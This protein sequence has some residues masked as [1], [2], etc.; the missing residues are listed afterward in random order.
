MV[1]GKEPKCELLGPFALVIQ[2]LMGL[3]A[4]LSL[5]YKRQKEHPQRPWWVWFF[6]V[7]KQVIGSAGLHMINLLLSILISSQDQI[8][9][10]DDN[11]CN[12]YFISILLDTTVGV[13][14]LWFFLFVDHNWCAKMGM[15]DIVSGE[16]GSPPKWIAFFKQASIY[17][18]AMVQMKMALSVFI[19]FTGNVIDDLGELLIRWASF[20]PRVQVFFVMMAFP[21]VMNSLQYYL[22]DTIIQSSRYHF[23]EPL[24]GAASEVPDYSSISS[25]D[26]ERDNIQGRTYT[27]AISSQ[28]SSDNDAEDRRAG[29][30]KSKV[31]S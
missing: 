30:G 2:I 25:V 17:M 4:I 13:P 3:M 21:L 20:D 19:Y 5:V 11:P 10:M 31:R 15:T 6:D 1:L 7:A 27:G 29:K 24:L 12:W 28:S 22:I 9:D 8:P 14:I 16:Y 18:T 23:S 26:D